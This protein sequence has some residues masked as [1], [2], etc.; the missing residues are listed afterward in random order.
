MHNTLD[1][2]KI[3]IDIHVNSW[4]WGNELEYYAFHF[5]ITYKV[6]KQMIIIKDMS[7]IVKFFVFFFAYTDFNESGVT[8][9]TAS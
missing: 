8:M 6:K 9:T 1:A 2:K 4:N 7:L 5:K 3:I